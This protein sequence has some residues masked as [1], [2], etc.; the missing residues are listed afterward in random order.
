V[1][2][3]LAILD[4]VAVASFNQSALGLE[5]IRPR[6]GELLALLEES[7]GGELC[8]DLSAV[9]LLTAGGIGGIVMLRR[10]V[11][12]AGA[13]LV[14]TGVCGMVHEVLR[15]CGL[16]DVLEIQALWAA[17]ESAVV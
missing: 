6:L 5:D 14:L 15:L 2:R 13:R 17:E 1:N 11:D 9:E 7:G 10:A 3:C 8:V 16:L 4:G 12:A